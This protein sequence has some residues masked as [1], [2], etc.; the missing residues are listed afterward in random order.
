MRVPYKSLNP[1][2]GVTH[3]EIQDDAILIDFSDGRFRYLYN[4]ELP[5]PAHVEAMKQRAVA[6][7]G[8]TTYINQHVRDRYARRWAISRDPR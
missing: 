1:D 5:G 7:K 2:A 6:G 8:L 4:E 3:Y